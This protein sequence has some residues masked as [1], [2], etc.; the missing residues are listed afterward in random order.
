MVERL[1]EDRFPVAW[2]EPWDRCGLL[3]G[4]REALVTNVFVTLDPTSEALSLA[5]AAGA[6]VLV[7]HHPVWLEP[8][9]A[10][11]ADGRSAV[12]FEAASLGIVLSASVPIL[13]A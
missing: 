1:L 12:A 3:V 13:R 2:A 10:L 9:S 7:S 6:N 4:D 11:T 5:V 8:P